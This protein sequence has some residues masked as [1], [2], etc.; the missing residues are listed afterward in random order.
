M[1]DG[2]I[3]I[4]PDGSAFMTMS[5]PLPDSHWLYEPHYNIP[6]MP[7]RMSD[8]PAREKMVDAI[9]EA[10]MY[11][12]RASTMNGKEDDFDPD[13]MVQNFVV[14]LIGYFTEDGLSS[15][16]EFNPTKI[17]PLFDGI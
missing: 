7:L 9:W 16:K 17:P 1:S 14:G 2:E 8:G 13:A 4:L 6:P 12:V 11:A 5:F 10:G 15:D 3:T